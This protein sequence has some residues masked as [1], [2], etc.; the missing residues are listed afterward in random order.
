[1]EWVYQPTHAGLPLQ[2]VKERGHPKRIVVRQ[3]PDDLP[4]SFPGVEKWEV[5]TSA[6]DIYWSIH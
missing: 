4:V 3:S 1:M 6:M 2:E 5:V